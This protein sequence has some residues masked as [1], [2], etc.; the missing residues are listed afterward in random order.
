MNDDDG[1]DNC[2]D[3]ADDDNDNDDTP[4]RVFI[5]YG[6]LSGQLGKFTIENCLV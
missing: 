3:N 6:L 2:R 4:S 5:T 1:D